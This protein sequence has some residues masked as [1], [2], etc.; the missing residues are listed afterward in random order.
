METSTTIT[1]TTTAET[2]LTIV[3]GDA[4]KSVKL[5]GTITLTSG[6]NKVITYKLAAGTHTI[7][8]IDTTNL[9][10]LSVE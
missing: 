2:T 9:F 6:T 5:D 1:F 4:E 7:S 8:K 3:L 10:Y